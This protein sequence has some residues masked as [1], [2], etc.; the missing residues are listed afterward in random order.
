MR[1]NELWNSLSICEK[2]LFV[3]P[4]MCMI[5]MLLLSLAITALGPIEITIRPI[6]AA[7]EKGE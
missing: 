3:I 5:L 4:T 2:A 6:P 7:H 1:I